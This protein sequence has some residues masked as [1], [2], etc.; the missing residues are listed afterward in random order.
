MRYGFR[1]FLLGA[2]GLAACAFTARGDEGTEVKFDTLDGVTLK[3][4][5]FTADPV[6]PAKPKNATVL[7]LHNIDKDKGGS[8]HQDGWDDLAK[9]LSAQGYSVLSFDFR[10]FGKSHE[11]SE[12]FWNRV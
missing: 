8:S 5:F 4:T 7:L 6:A 2:L 9:A 3:G 12:A 11:V 10:G 1:L